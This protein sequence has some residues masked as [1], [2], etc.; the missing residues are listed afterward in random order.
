MKTVYDV[1]EALDYDTMINVVNNYRK[2][3]QKA[4]QK[5]MRKK[6]KWDSIFPICKSK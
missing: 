3:Q 4:I 2:A 1:K 5:P 6:N